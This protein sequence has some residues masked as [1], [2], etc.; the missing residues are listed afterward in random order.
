MR[1]AASRCHADAMTQARA[2]RADTA[3]GATLRRARERAGLGMRELAALLELSPA[4][5]SDA[6]AG[7][8]PRRSTLLRYLEKLPSLPAHDLIGHGAPGVPRQ[9]AATWGFMRDAFGFSVARLTYEVVV[10]EDGARR[11]RLEASE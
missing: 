9:S 1:R 5:I 3:L 4:T 6:E 10:G 2:K 11:T 7:G 8:D